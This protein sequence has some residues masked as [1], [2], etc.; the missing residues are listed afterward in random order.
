MMMILFYILYNKKTGV[1]KGNIKFLIKSIIIIIFSGI[2][3]VILLNLMGRENDLGL[4]HYL[5]IYVG[6]P[7]VNLDNYLAVKQIYLNL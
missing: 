1:R 4:L 2:G 7:L 5:F 3:F 6:A